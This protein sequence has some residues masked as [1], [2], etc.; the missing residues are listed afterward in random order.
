MTMNMMREGKSMPMT[1]GS[2]GKWLA[3]DCGSVKP[4]VMPQP[5]K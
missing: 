3:A 4:P 2:S 5:A 1:M